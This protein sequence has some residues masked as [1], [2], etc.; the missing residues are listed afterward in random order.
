M[1]CP[2]PSS[3]VECTKALDD[4]DSLRDQLMLLNFLA[5][6]QQIQALGSARSEVRRTILNNIEPISR[7]QMYRSIVAL[8]MSKGVYSMPQEL[9]D[10]V[11]SNLS[12]FPAKSAADAALPIMF[13]ENLSL[14]ECVWRTVFKDETWLRL[15]FEEYKTTPVLLGADLSRIPDKL[16]KNEN[17]N[18]Y[19]VLLADDWSGGLFFHGAD[20]KFET[21]RNSLQEHTYNRDPY[22]NCSEVTVHEI[23]FSSGITLNIT[24]VVTGC[25]CIEM[26]DLQVLFEKENV[27]TA[28]CP[29][30]GPERDPITIVKGCDIVGKEGVVENVG[31]INP[32]CSISLSHLKQQSVQQ[33]FCQVGLPSL[34]PIYKDGENY[35]K[36]KIQGWRTY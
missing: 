16:K 3:L 36:G 21:F 9:W 8:Q 31:N 10:D 13:T 6:S 28:Y 35:P 33:V 25:E 23:S 5:P 15:A 2:P 7:R 27:Q 29:W 22:N 12:S 26:P 1:S 17:M 14:H 19:M 32:I 24:Q 11:A 20:E 30:I 4:L 34:S 18:C